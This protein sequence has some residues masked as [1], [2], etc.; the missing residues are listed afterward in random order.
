MRSDFFVFTENTLL[1]SPITRHR[2]S[3]SLSRFCSTRARFP[4]SPL[5]RRQ[6][7]SKLPALPFT[8]ES[9]LLDWI[10]LM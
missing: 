2:N 7:S 10:R 4:N 6:P 5:Y 8:D 9:R 3:N 1:Y